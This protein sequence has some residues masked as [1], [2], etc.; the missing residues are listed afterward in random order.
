MNTLE[1][2]NILISE[3]EK[4]DDDQFLSALKTIL[5]SRKT[6]VNYSERYNE[7][8]KVAEEDIQSGNFYSHNEM[9]DQIEQ[10]KKK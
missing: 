1:L 5:D 3:I 9:K 7:D 10:W 4:I 2:K 8:L 6:P